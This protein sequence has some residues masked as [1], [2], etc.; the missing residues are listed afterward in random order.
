MTWLKGVRFLRLIRDRLA[1]FSRDH[2]ETKSD[3]RPRGLIPHV[4]FDLASDLRNDCGN[5]GAGDGIRDQGG[6]GGDAV[7]NGHV[8]RSGSPGIVVG[9][10]IGDGGPLV[11]LTRRAVGLGEVVGCEGAGPPTQAADIAEPIMARLIAVV[12]G[13]LEGDLL[14]R[15]LTK[16]D[17]VLG[18]RKIAPTIR[19]SGD[20]AIG[21]ITQG[22][23]LDVRQLNDLE[24]VVL[25]AIN[26][27]GH[28]RT[29]HKDI[30]LKVAIGV[31]PRISCVVMVALE[32]A[33]E[34]KTKAGVPVRGDRIGLFD[35]GPIQVVGIAS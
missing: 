14:A 3:G 15:I 21:P 28:Y 8:R 31:G 23:N 24:K 11:D 6:I 25:P 7:G 2:L 27:T 20:I 22:G 18:P 12:F 5:G 17:G 10:G 34:P 30:D 9:Q 32:N 33:R 4:P 13:G 26:D 19:G 35:L 1:G 29:P 16:I